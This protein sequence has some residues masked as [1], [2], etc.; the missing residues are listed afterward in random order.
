MGDKINGSGPKPAPKSQKTPKVS[1]RTGV[2][3]GRQ[4]AGSAADAAARKIQD[5]L[6]AGGRFVADAARLGGGI[7]RVAK[8]RA[9]A[10]AINTYNA[11]LSTHEGRNRV[12]E[13][14]L[15]VPG[16]GVLAWA[17]NHGANAAYHAPGAIESA[18]NAVSRATTNA[19]LATGNAIEAGQR[20][21]RQKLANF[22]WD[23]KGATV[24]SGVAKAAANLSGHLDQAGTTFERAKQVVARSRKELPQHTVKAGETL[25]GLAEALNRD[26]KDIYELNKQAIG[27][28]PNRLTPG[29]RLRMPTKRDE[30]TAKAEGQAI[31]IIEQNIRQAEAMQAELNRLGQ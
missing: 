24:D 19:A 11:D 10:E 22:F 6:E 15:A 28:D 26:W 5:G 31:D 27:P 25:A 1:I 12:L 13:K 2:E 9:A 16:L 14:G 17:A 21:G 7:A 3:A 23:E 30:A 29:T 18:T 4:L 20:A 8:R